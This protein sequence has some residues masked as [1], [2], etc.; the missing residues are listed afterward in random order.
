M[1]ELKSPIQPFIV[2]HKGALSALEMQSL[3]Q[4]Y[5]PIIGPQAVNFYLLLMQQFV[6]DKKISNQRVHSTLFPYVNG[7]L[8]VIDEARLRLE[9]IGLMQTYKKTDMS[10]QARYATLLYDMQYPLLLDEFLSSPLLSNALINQLGD[11]AFFE[12]IK[13]WEI[14]PIE[15]AEYEDV[16]V[17]YSTVFHHSK[18]DYQSQISAIKNEREFMSHYHKIPDQPVL[19]SFDYAKLMRQLMENKLPHT[20][21]GP[22]LKAEAQA[23]HTVYGLDEE[24][25]YQLIMKHY[26]RSDQLIDY[27]ALK[28]EASKN[29][30]KD[31][32]ISEGADSGTNNSVQFEHKLNIEEVKQQYPQLMESDIELIK[33]C[34]QKSPEQFLYQLKMDFHGFATQQ[35]ISFIKNIAKVSN[36]SLPVQSFL[37]YYLLR[38]KQRTDYQ[39]G[40]SERVAN[41]WQQK[42]IQSVPQAILYV[43]QQLKAS[44]V[45]KK[46]QE[47]ARNQANKKYTQ[48]K[49]KRIEQQPY[50]MKEE[51]QL[52]ENQVNRINSQS[53]AQLRNR[54]GKIFEKGSDD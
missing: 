20:L 52:T 31:H 35:E 26:Q 47:N 48:S 36:L 4:L 11:E 30:K 14:A 32:R 16:S 8:S 21:I 38:I 19:E 17:S 6:N 37:V 33:L 24:S 27:N 44:T 50:W 40:E 43:R 28:M 12:I 25:I 45:A 22:K 23:L 42:N 10:L 9:A 34:H 51:N 7:G 54:L 49:V 3:I 2:R 1:S 5:Q 15:I 18:N 39:K 41:E 46:Q 29:I 53:E 13:Q